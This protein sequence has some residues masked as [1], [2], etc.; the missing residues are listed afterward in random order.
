MTN[1]DVT[2]YRYEDLP[3]K[4]NQSRRLEIPVSNTSNARVIF[5]A[6]SFRGYGFYHANETLLITTT[7]TATRYDTCE[8]APTRISRVLDEVAC[9]ILLN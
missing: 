3:L 4:I 7:V 2:Y 5:L 6:Q 8:G 9:K 1:F